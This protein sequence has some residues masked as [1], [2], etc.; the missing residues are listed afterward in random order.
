MSYG[1]SSDRTPGAEAEWPRLTAA[2]YRGVE[3]AR[4]YIL[5]HRIDTLGRPRCLFA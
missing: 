2:T 3:K 1:P 4:A 5:P